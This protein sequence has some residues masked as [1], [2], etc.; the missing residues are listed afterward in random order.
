M[1]ISV[2]GCAGLFVTNWRV[3]RPSKIDAGVKVALNRFGIAPASLCNDE[4]WNRIDA[5]NGVGVRSRYPFSLHLLRDIA[6]GRS[7]GRR[8]NLEMPALRPTH[9]S[10]RT[11]RIESANSEFQTTGID[12]GRTTP[13]ERKRIAADGDYELHQPAEH[14]ASSLAV[15]SPDI[16]R[17]AKTIALGNGESA[18]K[19]VGQILSH[20][21]F[22]P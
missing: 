16:E 20:R 1:S 4:D 5:C 19:R 8:S 21:S 2:A 3:N 11:G 13:H 14:S 22:V 18:R 6:G 15:A 9:D 17:A 12:G 7:S 10:A